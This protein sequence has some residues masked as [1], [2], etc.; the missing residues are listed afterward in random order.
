MDYLTLILGGLAI[1][2]LV[3]APIGPVNL[4]CIR[5]T[6]AY[7][8]LNGFLAGLGAALGDGVFAVIAGFG[9]TAAG[10]L[11]DGM[12]FWIQGV[13]ALLLI[14]YGIAIMR[15][16]PRVIHNPDGTLVQVASSSLYGAIASS[17]ALTITNPATM[18]GFAAFFA[19]MKGLVD[20]TESSLYTFILVMSVIAGSSLWWACVTGVTSIFRKSIEPSTMRA[21]N[22][23][24][25]A[26]IL[27][28]GLIF[29]GYAIGERL[30]PQDVPAGAPHEVQDG[31]EP[32]TAPPPAEP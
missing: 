31:V 17:F 9:L 22:I 32:Q 7:G 23:G 28:T 2:V 21:M 24:S 16:V 25:G 13:G 6:L 8:P 4:I 3:A 15:A 18:V 19:G 14:V 12:S 26:L 20:Y 29:A 27:I 1:G 30:K 10:D 5:R 11:I